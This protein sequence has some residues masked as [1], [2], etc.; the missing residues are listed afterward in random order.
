M[1]GEEAPYPKVHLDSESV[2][3]RQDS[4]NGESGETSSG[5][6]DGGAGRRRVGDFVHQNRG[7][8]HCQGLHYVLPGLPHGVEVREHSAC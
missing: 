8:A 3:T 4:S 6:Y 5:G 2:K 1:S 7:A